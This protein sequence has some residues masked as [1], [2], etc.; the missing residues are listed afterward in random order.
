MA[1]VQGQDAAVR[2]HGVVT[3]LDLHR[4]R[5][6][7]RVEERLPPHDAALRGGGRGGGG[8]RTAPPGGRP[9]GLAVPESALGK[10]GPELDRVEVVLEARPEALQELRQLPP[11]E[12]AEVQ[13]EP[14]LV[15]LVQDDALEG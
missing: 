7:V 14:V 2:C 9:V 3:A 11:E 10:A 4:R 5:P 8:R 6:G 1:V 15:E 12:V 13:A